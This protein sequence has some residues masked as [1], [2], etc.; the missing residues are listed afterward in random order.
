MLT[1]EIIREPEITWKRELFKLLGYNPSPAQWLCHRARARFR[2]LFAA[3]RLGKSMVA[4]YEVA[5]ELLMP[6]R[7]W[8][9]GLWKERLVWLVA[10]QYSLG[11][12][13]FGW[14][15]EALHK[16]QEIGLCEI[17]EEKF[18]EHQGDMWVSVEIETRIS[19]KEIRR[20]T[21]RCVVK[22]GEKPQALLGSEMDFLVL[23]EGSQ[24]DRQVWE[25]YLYRALSARQGRVLI[26]TTPAGHNWLY[27]TFFQKAHP[28][29]DGRPDPYHQLDEYRQWASDVTSAEPRILD[30]Y[31]AEMFSIY[32][33]VPPYDPVEV[34]RAKATLPEPVFREQ[35]LGEFVRFSGSVF[36]EFDFPR[37]VVSLTDVEFA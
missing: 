20:L 13:E 8:H 37:H 1:S 29:T 31:W 19:M 16:A 7:H 4:G 5:A 24:F 3:S 30:D 18:N 25:R 34:R 6:F 15:M 21:N 26:P 14:L 2:A 28:D 23:C 36:S 22:T 27:E 9:E 33:R 12:K 11:A 10:P 17:T 35:Y 32:D